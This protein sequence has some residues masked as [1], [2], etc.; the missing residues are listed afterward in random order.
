M[1]EIFTLIPFE[2][3]SYTDHLSLEHTWQL[4]WSGRP[5]LMQPSSIWAVAKAARKRER[6]KRL[7]FRRKRSTDKTE[8]V[9]A[10]MMWLPTSIQYIQTWIPIYP[11]SSDFSNA[12][13]LVSSYGLSENNENAFLAPGLG[14]LIFSIEFAA[15][16][17]QG[18]AQ[19]EWYF[20]VWD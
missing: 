6:I 18:C 11:I 12:V 7:I 1:L 9:R 19:F 3:Y 20:F 16:P 13:V 15:A 10:V 8:I 14:F 4:G 5:Q 2:K 17:I